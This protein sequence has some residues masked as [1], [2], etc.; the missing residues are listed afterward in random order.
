MSGPRKNLGAAIRKQRIQV[1][2]T[3]E[4]FGRKARISKA[5]L[6]LV[7]NGLCEPP[8]DD[9][10]AAIAKV[11]GFA[12][13]DLEWLVALARTP[14]IVRK[15]LEQLE[16]DLRIETQADKLEMLVMAERP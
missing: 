5:Y 8:S 2:L 16:A 9:K 3:L 12:V 4:D 7:E 11:T 13:A 15:R 6:S 10:I 1:G 14:E